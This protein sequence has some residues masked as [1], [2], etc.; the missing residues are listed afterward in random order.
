MHRRIKFRDQRRTQMC[1]AHLAG[2]QIKEG[3]IREE[4]SLKIRLF[5]TKVL[6]EIELNRSEDFSD[7]CFP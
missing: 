2:W 1:P 7:Y 4:N 6:D 3:Q 5:E